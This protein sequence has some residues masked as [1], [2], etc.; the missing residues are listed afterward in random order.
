MNPFP[1]IL[2]EILNIEEEDNDD[3]DILYTATRRSERFSQGRIR[4][5]SGS[6]P[7]HRMVNR[8]RVEGHERLYHDYFATPYVYGSF[9]SKEV[10]NESS[11]F[12]SN[13]K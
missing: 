1:N 11:S 7:G 4:R 3:L 6:V 5:H 8:D 13:Y 2:R 9:F 12:S 10:P